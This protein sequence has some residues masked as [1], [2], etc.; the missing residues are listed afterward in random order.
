MCSSDLAPESV[1]FFAAM[2]ALVAT[3]LITNYS[4]N[5]VGMAQHF[6]HSLSPMG[7]F[8][9]FVFMYTQGVTSSVLSL[10]LQNPK[11][12]HMIPYLGMTAGAFA[13][14]YLSEMMMDPSVPACRDL[15]MGKASNWAQKTNDKV[16]NYLAGKPAP[17]EAAPKSKFGVKEQENPCDKAFEYFAVNKKIWEYA[18]QISSMLL[19]SYVAGIAQKTVSSAI[20]KLTGVDL[21]M[22]LAPG[23][24]EVSAARLL[25][26]KGTQLYFFT[27]I[28]AWMN[29]RVNYVWKNLFDGKDFYDM[30]SHIIS[31][32]NRLN[33]QGWDD[34][35]ELQKSIKQFHE[36]MAAWRMMNLADVYE[37]HQAWQ[38]MLHQ[39]T[40]QY[41]SSYEFY[42][43]FIN[44]VRNSNS[45]S[46]GAKRLLM[47]Y[48][49]NGVKDAWLKEGKEDMYYDDPRGSESGQAETVKNVANFID[50]VIKDPKSLNLRDSETVAVK[51]MRDKFRNE[52]NLVKAEGIQQLF[53]EMK[54]MSNNITTSKNYPNLLQAIYAGLGNPDPKLQGGRGFLATFENTPT[55]GNSIK[56]TSYYRVV[57]NFKTPKITDYYVMQMICGPK[58]NIA[59]SSSEPVVRTTSGFP[60]IFMPPALRN[61]THDFSKECQPIIDGENSSD[62]IYSRKLTPQKGGRTYTGFLEY[63][64]FN[65]SQD[66]LNDQTDFDSW[67]KATTEVPVRTAFEDFSKKYDQIVVNMIRGIYNQKRTDYDSKIARLSDQVIEM[68][69]NVFDVIFHGKDRPYQSTFNRGPVSNAA[70]NAI[71]QQERVYLAILNEFFKAPGN[72]FYFNLEDILVASK[73]PTQPL[74]KEVEN[75]FAALNFTIKK[76]KIE[77][78]DGREVIRGGIKNSEIE[79]RVKNISTALSNVAKALN[80]AEKGSAEQKH[81]NAGGPNVTLINGIAQNDIAVDLLERLQALAD[82]MSYYGTIAN[83]VN[84]D[85]IR[86]LK[87]DELDQ[88]KAMSE[89]VKEMQKQINKKTFNK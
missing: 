50:E 24:M 63:L 84:W 65:V 59:G 26:V 74:L 2:G 47:K 71:F 37:A 34:S 68:Y 7:M 8:G 56:N 30:Q 33:T 39:L 89:K 29:R 79:E 82:E 66:I 18:P 80:V 60:A 44:E 1:M 55:K 14:N 41:S 22:A 69:K 70:M 45:D 77:N 12:G 19:S 15:M 52:D 46:P 13:Q 43:S 61:S 81:E 21:M 48:P 58:V 40:S 3:Q 53:K 78:V 38:D 6:E 87:K 42:S 17:I 75:Q 86:E 54:N 11:F 88:Q 5:P 31:E 27:A 20:V 76:I 83:A 28:D 67:W 36:K 64:V 25:L 10:Y 35:T 51:Q 16:N 49:L 32:V 72:S 85:K 57:G 23:A 4:Q 9:F 73:A 62:E